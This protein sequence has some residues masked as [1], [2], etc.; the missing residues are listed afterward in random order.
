MSGFFSEEIVPCVATD[1]VCPREEVSSGTSS[2]AIL[3]WNKSDFN[4]V[5][6]TFFVVTVCIVYLFNAFTFDLSVS[7]Y[8]K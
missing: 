5:I 7:L 2:V 8:L 4:I 3:D 6:S 1:S